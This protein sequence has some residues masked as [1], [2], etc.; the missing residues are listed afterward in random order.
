[1]NV[2]NVQ[3]ANLETTLDAI[4]VLTVTIAMYRVQRRAKHV[5]QVCTQKTLRHASI[6][7]L[8]RIPA[9]RP[10]VFAICVLS[11]HFQTRPGRQMRRRA[12]RVQPTHLDIVPV[13]VHVWQIVRLEHILLTQI[14][15]RHALQESI[16]TKMRA[17]CVK[18]VLLDFL[19]GTDRH[20]VRRVHGENTQTPKKAVGAWIVL[21]VL[22]R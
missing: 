15:V 2:N 8:V 10:S 12:C 1:M 11:A 5:V 19:L 16:T 22:L 6:V 18:A 20:L 3:L 21:L 7:R 14:F 17:P 9:Q 4:R 13:Q